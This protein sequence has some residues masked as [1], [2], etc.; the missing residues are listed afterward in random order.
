[1]WVENKIYVG[2]GTLDLARALAQRPEVVAILP[3]TIYNIP[4]L[5]QTGSAASTQGIEWNVSK[6]RADQV[7]PTTTGS[8]IVVAN[9]DSGVQF[10]HPALVRQY[11]GNTG[12]GFNHVGN[13]KDETKKCHGAPC[14]D[15]GHGTH[16]MGTIVGND[17]GL[18]QIGV[19]PGAKWIACKA[20]TTTSC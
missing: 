5:E 8:G 13:W 10:D 7:W 2:G 4:K 1:F 20:C 18:N 12:S 17:G 14:D 15:V 6:I 11:R 16:T 9:I 3:E 19:A